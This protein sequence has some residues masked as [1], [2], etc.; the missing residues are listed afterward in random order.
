MS[1]LYDDEDEDVKEKITKFVELYEEFLSPLLQFYIKYKD[2]NELREGIEDVFKN[3][4][5]KGNDAFLKNLF[6]FGQILGDIPK[7]LKY[8]ENFV[9]GLLDA[10]IKRS[11]EFE[12]EIPKSFF[13]A[14]KKLGFVPKNL[15]YSPENLKKALEYIA[16]NNIKVDWEVKRDENGLYITI[17]G[18]RVYLD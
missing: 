11:I 18:K 16:K 12:Y 17:E 7:D 2:K 5:K 10:V 14:F 3:E 4:I 1:E 15:E 13:D 8:P 6:L 9:N